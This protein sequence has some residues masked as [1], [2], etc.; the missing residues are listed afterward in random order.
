MKKFPI[1]SENGNKYLIR[2]GYGAF[3]LL[4]VDVCEPYNGLF[5]KQKFRKV[6]NSY[7]TYN[8]DKLDYDY[9]Q[10]AKDAVERYE[11]SLAED[12][13]RAMLREYN[14]NKFAEWDGDCR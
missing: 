4:Y 13:R 10:I 6:N 3:G 11:E 1:I 2:M 14:A 7:E 5:G 12:S 9:V 8:A